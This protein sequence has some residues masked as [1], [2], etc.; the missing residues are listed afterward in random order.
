ML[1]IDFLTR[2]FLSVF[3]AKAQET[4]AVAVTVPGGDVDALRGQVQVKV[5]A[6]P[7]SGIRSLWLQV[8]GSIVA[9]TRVSPLAYT[10]DTT[11]APDGSHLLEGN[12]Q[13]KNRKSAQDR[14]VVNVNN[15]VRRQGKVAAAGF[16]F[17]FGGA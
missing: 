12:V 8:D 3:A 10:W 9:N 4:P 15:L 16:V 7:Q 14:L 6:A 17:L 11:R 13:Y 5:Q 2:T 1:R